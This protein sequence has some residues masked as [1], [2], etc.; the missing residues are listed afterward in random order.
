MVDYFVD[1]SAGGG[2]NGLSPAS[3]FLS[4]QSIPW[5]NGDRAWLR[6]T[7]IE[8]LE[9]GNVYFDIRTVNGQNVITSVIGWPEVGYPLYD[10]R[11]AA[12]ISAGWDADEPATD[13]YS[14][15]GYKFPLLTG[16]TANVTNA[17]LVGRGVYFVNIGFNQA[18][19]SDLLPCKFYSGFAAFMNNVLPTRGFGPTGQNPPASNNWPRYAQKLIWP[20]STAVGNALSTAAIFRYNHL[21]LPPQA[22]VGDGGLFPAGLQGNEIDLLENQ[23]NSVTYFIDNNAVN[24]GV[25]AV[26]RIGRAVGIKPTGG[27]ASLAYGPNIGGVRFACDDYYGEGPVFYNGPNQINT[28]ATTSLEAMHNGSRATY[29]D[30]KSVSGASQQFGFNYPMNATLFKAVSVVS[31]ETITFELP[32]YIGSTAVFSMDGIGAPHMMLQAKGV[33]PMLPFTVEPGSSSLWSG[34]LVAGGS[35]W[36]ARYRFTPTETASV[37]L[38]VTLPAVTSATSGGNVESYMLFSEPYSV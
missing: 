2:G 9:H 5:S 30:A 21:V 11:P 22:V 4:M 19:A 33:C 27:V 29:V 18:A 36:I 24:I 6:R 38:K 26:A 17:T 16:S 3:A 32:V 7:H 37:Q 25:Q 20:L 15:Y 23:S 34:S 1:M 31:G 35:A 13:I 28:R 10:N 12:G 8:T 14:V